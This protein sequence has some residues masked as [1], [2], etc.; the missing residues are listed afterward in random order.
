MCLEGDE[1]MGKVQG[2]GDEGGRGCSGPVREA[3][4]CLSPEQG[5]NKSPG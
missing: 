1:E 3:K 2:P 5:P 4:P